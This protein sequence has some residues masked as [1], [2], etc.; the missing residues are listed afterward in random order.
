MNKKKEERDFKKMCER[1]ILIASQELNLNL[2]SLSKALG[3]K[4]QSPLT[5]VKKGEG[6]IGPEKLKKFALLKNNKGETPNLN[7]VVTGLGKKMLNKDH[8]KHAAVATEIIESI[9]MLNTQKILELIPEIV[10]VS[11]GK[12]D[13]S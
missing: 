8:E 10:K 13:I 3:Y 4:N 9:G 12:K 2:T 1:L 11:N 5:K 6:F 7:W